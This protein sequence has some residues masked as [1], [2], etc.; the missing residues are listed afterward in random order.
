MAIFKCS[1]Y[2]VLECILILNFLLCSFNIPGIYPHSEHRDLFYI[3]KIIQT[4]IN[5]TTPVAGKT[6][7]KTFHLLPIIFQRSDK[8]SSTS[9]I[10]SVLQVTKHLN[11]DTIHNLCIIYVCLMKVYA[12]FITLLRANSLKFKFQHY[13]DVIRYSSSQPML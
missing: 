4:L 8:N 13:S 12:Y 11:L 2:N 10:I 1:V 9:C 7:Y 6:N 5:F 3:S